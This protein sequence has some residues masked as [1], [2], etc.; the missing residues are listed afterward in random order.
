MKIL[1]L[2]IGGTNTKI[3]LAN[4]NG[5]FEKGY[6]VVEKTKPPIE[7]FL[8]EIFEKYL[9]NA[10]KIGISIASNVNSKGVVV[11]STNLEIPKNFPLKEFVERKTGKECRVINDG[12][13]S[14]IAVSNIDE[15]KQFKNIVSVTL[16][17]G[18]GGGIILNG[19][20]LTSKTG[21]DSEIG[22]ITIVPNGKRC[23]CGNYGCVEAYCGERGIVERFNEKS[24][25]EIEN[26]LE[27]KKLLEK[28]DRIARDIVIETG[29]YLGLALAII[30]NILGIEA[31]ALGGGVCGLGG[32]LIETIKSYLRKNCFGS[33]IGIFPDV[34][35]IKEYQYLSLKGAAELFNE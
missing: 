16:G 17:T 7:N 1:A 14:A 25:K 26:T 10:E 3:A 5:N 15:F 24:E 31:F 8:S 9:N 12:N 22:H 34:K 19:K 4:K 20:V 2:D 18:I 11:N 6:P 23:N 35:V 30:T 21:L 28:N 27:L 33:K 13:A 32:L 29:N